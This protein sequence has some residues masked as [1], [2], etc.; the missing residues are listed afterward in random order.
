MKETKVTEIIYKKNLF[1]R[2]YVSWYKDPRTFSRYFH[3]N[4]NKLG[5]SMLFL[6][7]FSIILKT[8]TCA[9]INSLTA[10]NQHILEEEFCFTVSKYEKFLHN[11]KVYQAWNKLWTGY[12][13]AYICHFPFFFNTMT[14]TSIR[15]IHTW[16]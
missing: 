13:L 4:R 14:Q 3:L 7:D 1:H 11:L 12:I 10:Y 6:S 5:I 2:P 15:C 8:V 16:S 9:L